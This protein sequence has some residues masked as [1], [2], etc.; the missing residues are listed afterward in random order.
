MRKGNLYSI[1]FVV[2]IDLLGFGLILPL[3]PFYAEE[4]GATPFVVG[5]LTASYAAAQLVGAPVLG[6]LSDRFGRRPV[7]LVSIAGTLVGFLLL[8]VADP[9]GKGLAGWFGV[10]PSLSVLVVLFFSRILDGL[11]G[12]NITVAQA[13]ITDITDASN[14]AKGLGLIGAA[15]GLGFILGP[16]TGG[17]LS[18]W[19]Y[20]VPALA[21]AGLSALNLL[22]VTFFLPESLTAEVRQQRQAGRV[23]KP[24]FTLSALWAALN[25]PRVGPLLHIRFFFGLAF[26]VFQSV[27]ALYAQYRLGLDPRRT[28]FILA[29]VGLLSVLVQGVGVGRLSKRYSDTRLIF[30]GAIL[31]GL[32]L[33]GWAFTPNVSLLLVLLIPLALSGGVLNTVLSSALSKSVY[34]EEIGGTL[35]LAASV[36]STTRVL[37]PSAGGFLL[38]Q[39]GAW[40]PGIFA[41]LLMSWVVS[42]AY[43]R[44]VVNPDPPL[45]V[46]AVAAADKALVR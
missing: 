1:F 4:Y 29:Y 20:A 39:F 35:G 18:A 40:A 22:S 24:S 25:R 10:S 43:R 12:G 13:Y 19:G 17:L 27:F 23:Q 46:R 2:F 15:F 32:S 28:G 3:L 36:E 7:L 38:G 14:R 45:E 34:P 42:F 16:A 33:L 26:A 11:T 6:R 8:G 31:M 44:L 9:L 41:A 21:A 5:L 30:S 37:A